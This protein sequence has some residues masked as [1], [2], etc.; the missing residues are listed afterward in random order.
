LE[1]K[2]RRLKPHWVVR[3]LGSCVVL[4]LIFWLLPTAEI[5]TSIRKVHF[6]LWLAVVGVFLL[7]HVVAAI[8]WWLLAVKGSGVSCSVALRAHFAG[9]AANLCLP[10]IAGGDVVRA[11]LVLKTSSDKARL[12]VGSLADRLIDTFAL[13]M[14]ACAAAMLLD[15]HAAV[16]AAPLLEISLFLVGASALIVIGLA[17]ANSLALGG[18]AGRIAS[19]GTYFARRPGALLLC[20]MLSLMVQ[21]I[22]VLLNVLLAKAI[23]LDVAL[24]SWFFA[25]PLA[26]LLALVPISI[27]GLGVREAAL[28]AL[29]APFGAKPAVAVAVGLLWQSVLLAGGLVGGIA[30]MLSRRKTFSMPGSERD[31]GV[32][33]LVEAQPDLIKR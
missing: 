14:L 25:W 5:W 32:I 15:G 17:V 30:L 12:A 19:V 31:A 28:A 9:L 29:L 6:G 18:L 21:T 24:E 33:G 7:G 13:I 8:K 16:A 3:I 22:F 20:L 11:G 10:G 1:D 27:S 23:G 4:G 2:A 26:K